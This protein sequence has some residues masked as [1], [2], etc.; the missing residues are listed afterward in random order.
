MQVRTLLE[1]SRAAS[2]YHKLTDLA[3]HVLYDSY[4]YP[5]LLTRESRNRPNPPPGDATQA[6][7]HVSSRPD[8]TLGLSTNSRLDLG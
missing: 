8:Q 2:D 7:I 1:R 6:E 5:G 4:R 3:T